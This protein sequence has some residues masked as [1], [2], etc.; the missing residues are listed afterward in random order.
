MKANT[1]NFVLLLMSALM[2]GSIWSSWLIADAETT[3]AIGYGNKG[4]RSF[5]NRHPRMRKAAKAAAIGAGIG[6]GVG[7][8]TGGSIAGSAAGSAGRS[9]GFSLVRTSK[10]WQ[11]AK[12]KLTSKRPKSQSNSVAGRKNKE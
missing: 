5:F 4:L 6:T 2:T 12:G 9:A 1:K 11:K 8:V 10:P 7:L 3:P